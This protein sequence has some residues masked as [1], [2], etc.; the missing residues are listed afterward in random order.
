[1]NLPHK[2]TI[3]IIHLV[4]GAA[5]RSKGMKYWYFISLI[6]AAAYLFAFLPKLRT[7]REPIAYWGCFVYLG[8]SAIWWALYGLRHY[9]G[10][11]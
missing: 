10:L 9:F 11:I 3:F 4:I 5:F 6:A 7:Q 2:D 8:A 1:M